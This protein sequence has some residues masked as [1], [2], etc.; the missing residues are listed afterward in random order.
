MNVPRAFVL[1][2][3]ATLLVVALSVGPAVAAE[4]EGEPVDQTEEPVGEEDEADED[5]RRAMA[6]TPRDRLGLLLLVSLFVG[7]GVA[8]MNGRK[9]MKGE[10][11]Q[12]SG[13][14]RWR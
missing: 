13:E 9:Q 10:H 5:H 14:F 1:L 12:A 2:V 6:D 3:S 11:S 7:G 4:E 8:L